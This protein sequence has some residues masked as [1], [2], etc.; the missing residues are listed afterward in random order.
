[1]PRPIVALIDRAALR[2][3]LAVARQ[4]AGTRFLW[5]VAKADAYG[6]G[7][8]SAVAAF[9]AADGL[10]LLDFAEA[11]RARSAGW[12]KPILLLEGFFAPDDLAVVERLDLTV[13]VHHE[14]QVRMLEH[15]AAARP[16]DVYLKL[17]SGMN[18]LGFAAAARVAAAVERLQALPHV[19]LRAFMTHLANADNGNPA[20]GRTSVE[21]QL[22]R[23]ARLCGDWR[24][25][26]SISNSAA[27][28][29]HRGIA[30]DAVRPGIVLYGAVPAPSHRAEALQLRPAMQLRSQLIAV[31]QLGVG[32]TVGYGAT[33]V[34]TQPLRI[35]VV[36]CGY[37]DGYPRS[38]PTGTP[39]AVAG[40]RVPIVGR[41]SMDM[42]CVDLTRAPQ[43]TVGS[44]VELWGQRV[45][46]DEVAAAAGTIGYE[47]LC[48]VSPR[49]PRQVEG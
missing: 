26:R 17:N 24:G 9:D 43:A 41:V 16:I 19:R 20:Q 39:V 30:D 25:A 10:A 46:V 37:A 38:V 33:F 49:V 35:G 7:V 22:Q 31:Q 21:E 42:L 47:L 2:H 3:N 13:V 6:H 18:R 48:K 36:A 8:E 23:F 34:A 44:E 15:H 11:Q 40:V 28:F 1:M 32:E 27:L 4:R 5:A 14:E 29:F 45:P 12:R